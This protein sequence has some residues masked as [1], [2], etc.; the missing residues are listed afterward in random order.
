M[1]RSMGS[2]FPVQWRRLLP[3]LPLLIAVL[4]SA[5]AMN[6]SAASAPTTTAPQ[7]TI[8]PPIAL[9]P[10]ATLT[11]VFRFVAVPDCNF[12]P[13][14]GCESLLL[15]RGLRLGTVTFLAPASPPPYVGS[16]VVSQTPAA[17]VFVLRNAAVDIAV[18]PFGP[19]SRP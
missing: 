12:L 10:L 11:P 7:L 3:A 14:T 9:T 13:Q 17:G 19:P 8:T 18:Q 1:L 2:R 16:H 15:S 4:A 5:P 6:A